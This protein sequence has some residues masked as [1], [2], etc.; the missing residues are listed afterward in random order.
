MGRRSVVCIG[1]FV[2]IAAV[3]DAAKHAVPEDSFLEVLPLFPP[4]PMGVRRISPYIQTIC[5]PVGSKN[6][7]SVIAASLIQ[8]RTERNKEQPAR[9]GGRAHW[10]VII[11]FEHRSNIF[12]R[13]SIR[14]MNARGIP[15]QRANHSMRTRAECMIFLL[16]DPN[17]PDALTQDDGKS[18]GKA[19][20]VETGGP[21]CALAWMNKE[22][23][24][25]DP[26]KMACLEGAYF[27]SVSRRA[28]FW[29]ARL[30]EAHPHGLSFPLS[31]RSCAPASTQPL[32]SAQEPPCHRI[33][34]A[35]LLRA[36]ASPFV[37][38]LPDRPPP[39]GPRC[40]PWPRLR[41]ARSPVPGS[42]LTN[43]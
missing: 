13:F 24:C 17:S 2:L 10:D 41:Q 40:N 8:H 34:P 7:F 1:L 23:G 5:S 43:K 22:R 35:S 39:R 26:R 18:G 25:K 21:S 29:G 28:A 14:S 32:M 9:Q 11:C 27:F 16:F 38:L 30:G 42:L 36:A 6:G 19:G 33:F 4:T 3:G 20:H 31:A 15:T 12:V 37:P